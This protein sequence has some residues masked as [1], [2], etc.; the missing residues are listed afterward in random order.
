M[1][2]AAFGE[3]MARMCP[4]EF[5]RLRQALP[6]PLEV[7]FAGAEAN[8]AV[9]IALFGGDAVFL[10][11]LP[12]DD[13]AAACLDTLRARGVDT[14]RVLRRP[15]TRMG[16]YFVER[17]ANQR[18]STVLYDRSHAAIATTPASSYDWGGSLNG[19]NWLHV[20]GI[21]PALSSHAAAA[22]LAAV[23]AA[24]ARG[25]TVSC[26][27]NFRAKLWCWEEG[28]DAR[29]LARKTMREILD[30]IDVIIGNEE[31]AS[32]VLG[33]DAEGSDVDSGDLR[34]D[35]YPEVARKIVDLHPNIGMVAV[36][37]R[38]SLSASHNKWGAMLFDGKSN[39]AH[40]APVVGDVYEPYA[41]THM[42]DRVGGGD[43]FAGALLFALNSP[44]LNDPGLAVR[45]A[46][47]ASCLAHSIPGDFNFVSRAEVERLMG[48]SASGRVLR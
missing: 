25:M 22:S 11:A 1:K 41:I 9:S 18:P 34:I 44:E 29:T 14:S 12:D 6:G 43:A 36:T 3:I 19:C 30:E 4:P 27:L 42:V 26:D 2:I 39:E 46:A 10:S 40:F 47:A 32:D 8:V 23:K 28:T 37:L 15:G 24:K 35:R 38:Q 33:I 13:L 21:T 17:G 31:D 48:G 7:T 20:T 45:F 5:M 16:I